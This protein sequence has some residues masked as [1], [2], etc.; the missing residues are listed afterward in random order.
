W[1]YVLRP[2][3]VLEQ[4]GQDRALAGARPSPELDHRRVERAQHGANARVVG[5]PFDQSA[6]H[7]E[8][9]SRRRSRT[10]FMSSQVGRLRLASRNSAA[11]WYVTRTGTPATSHQVPRSRPTG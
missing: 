11:G 5:R 6:A 9:V 8:A 7:A 10:I 1:R 2:G 4:P 3:F